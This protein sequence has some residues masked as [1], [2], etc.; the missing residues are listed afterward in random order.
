MAKTYDLQMIDLEPVMGCNLRCRMCHVSFMDKGVKY[1]DVS[2]IDW[3]FCRNKVIT[4]GAAFEPFIHPKINHVI[5]ELN[6][7][8]AR[9]TLLTNAHNLNKKTI[10]ALFESKLDSV[11]F[12]FD[13]VSKETYEEIRR[14]GNFDQ[15]I[16][17]IKNFI[18]QH[19]NTNTEF[20]IN[21]T[22]MKRN[23]HEV[24]QAPIFWN[25]IGIDLLRFIPMVVRE[26]DPY[27]HENNLLWIYEEH[28]KQFLDAVTTVKDHGLDIAVSS[29]IYSKLLPEECP[30]GIYHNNPLK[31]FKAC[32]NE[33]GLDLDSPIYNGCISPFTTA[34]IDWEGYVRICHNYII[35][36][37]LETDF[38]TI[39]KGEKANKLRDELVKGHDLCETCD[40]FKY[41]ISF[42]L[43]EDP[44]D[45]F[46]SNGFKRNHPEIFQQMKAQFAGE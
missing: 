23:L 10:P 12:S 22:V 38:E 26:N 4:I 1:L 35:G 43:I 18:A 37:I 3:E 7:V 11:T 13:G 24:K 34:R 25:E 27:L 39:W 42:E 32:H 14:G 17:N 16:E 31:N 9:I 33:N 46:F 21:F 41:C 20:C 45:T 8:N 40:Y 5:Q 44:V 30:K 29:K 6:R 2:K 15:T 19:K 36:N 28:K